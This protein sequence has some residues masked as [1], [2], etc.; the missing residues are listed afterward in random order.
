MGT[1]ATAK[2]LA[3]YIS[4]AVAGI[5]GLTYGLANDASM[6][7][8]L[9]ALFLLIGVLST[10]LLLLEE[11]KRRSKIRKLGKLALGVGVFATVF[12][13]AGELMLRL[14]FL[15]GESFGS[16]G[17][18]LVKR[19]ERDFRFNRFD[20]PSRGP[21]PSG[22]K[23]SHGTRILIQGDSITWG[24]GVRNEQQLFTSRLLA[25]LRETN[26]SVDMAVLARPGREIDGHLQQLKKWGRK[27]WPDVI[28]YQWYINDIELEKEHRP[29][30]KGHGGGC[31]FTPCCNGIPTFGSFWTSVSTGYYL[32][33]AGHMKATFRV[34]SKRVAQAGYRSNDSS[35]TGPCW[36]RN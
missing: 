17:G 22:P 34:T 19:F 16:H 4:L 8:Q 35:R 32:L 7:K 31:F 27:L 24:Q 3:P 9:G 36:R 28:I 23:H 11:E 29:Q 30:Q 13:L 18:P 1:P 6:P 15:E 12:F 10:P 2:A 5:I 20:G 25:R 21:E 14:V 33:P 26:V